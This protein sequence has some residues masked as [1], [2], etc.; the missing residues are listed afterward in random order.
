MDDKVLYEVNAKPD[1]SWEICRPLSWRLANFRSERVRKIEKDETPVPLDTGPKVVLHLI[2]HAS[3]NEAVEIDVK[4]L[5]NVVSDLMP[6]A[7]SGCSHRFNADGFLTET[8]SREGKHSGYLQVFRNGSFETVSTELFTTQ[9]E[10]GYLASLLFEREVI[11]VVSRL[12]RLTGT[13]GIPGTCSI[14]VSLLGARGV[15]MTVD[16]YR[17]RFKQGYPIDRDALI[18]PW[19]AIG[20]TDVSA[21]LRTSFDFV[22]QA[23]G[24]PG[25][26]YYDADGN[27]TQ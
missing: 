24:W 3:L 27:R 12:V 16:P 10:Q 5:Y 7:C 20:D 9:G 15:L 4:Q 19:A 2:P 11:N 8:S 26:Q 13:L 21:A 22:W 6:L 25:S 14:A 17:N 1:G 23:A 18:V